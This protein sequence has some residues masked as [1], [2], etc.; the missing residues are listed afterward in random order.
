MKGVHILL[1]QEA[2]LCPGS[3]AL[4]R[5]ASWCPRKD[6]R[7]EVHKLHLSPFPSWVATGKLFYLSEPWLP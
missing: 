7:L 5:K 6:T 2:C 1:L 3:C 4:V